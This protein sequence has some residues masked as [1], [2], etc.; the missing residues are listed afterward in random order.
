[1]ILSGVGLRE[2]TIELFEATRVD[3]VECLDTQSKPPRLLLSLS[4]VRFKPGV[5][6]LLLVSVYY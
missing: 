6:G 3:H 2:C 1:M 5:V 4:W